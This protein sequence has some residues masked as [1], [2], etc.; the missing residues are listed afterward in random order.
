MTQFHLDLIQNKF[1]GKIRGIPQCIRWR[2]GL[3]L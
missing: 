1:D 3:P 2:V